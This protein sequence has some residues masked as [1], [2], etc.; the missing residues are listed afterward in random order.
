MAITDAY[1]H[2]FSDVTA[3]PRNI[4]IDLVSRY[5]AAFGAIEAGKFIDKLFI[6]QNRESDYSLRF[7]D[8]ASKD[9][10]ER[11]DYVKLEIEGGEILEFSSILNVDD[12]VIFAPPP[13]LKFSR[14]KSLVETLVND[15]D[16]VIIERWGSKPWQIEIRG[17]LI[18]FKNRVYPSDEI[19]RLNRVW[20]HPGIINA[21][22]KQFEE[23]DIDSLYF[24]D[25][26]FQILEGFPDTIKFKINANAIKAVN[27]TLLKPNE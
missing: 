18:D 11:P 26:E 14:D 7:Y 24:K 6:E 16:A 4:T 13:V 12:S 15:D 19:K 25:I 22:G 9:F 23:K 27:W 1:K 10:K 8:A 5:A 21:I 2:A 3:F 17:L 20:Q